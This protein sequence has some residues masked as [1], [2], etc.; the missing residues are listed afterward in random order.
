MTALFNVDLA[1]S[2]DEATVQVPGTGTPLVLSLRVAPA[3]VT[4]SLS[5]SA[6]DASGVLVDVSGSVAGAAPSNMA[7]AVSGNIDGQMS[8]SGGGCSNNGHVWSLTPR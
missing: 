5:G 4:G 2:A 1:R 7:I 8:V 6:R 3:S